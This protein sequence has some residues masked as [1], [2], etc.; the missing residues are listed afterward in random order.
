MSFFFLHFQYATVTTADTTPPVVI[1]CPDTVTYTIPPGATTRVV[2]WLEPISTDNSGV[3]PTVGQSHRPGDTFRLGTTE[4]MY[5]FSDQ[6]GNTA[7][8]AFLVTIG[9]FVFKGFC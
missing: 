5:T 6:A 2:T 9:E 8:C 4:V 3:R 1:E 7:S